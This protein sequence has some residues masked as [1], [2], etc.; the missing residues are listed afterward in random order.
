LLPEQSYQ[1]GLAQL[2]ADFA[3]GPVLQTSQYAVLWAGH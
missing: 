1:R 3:Q 2:R